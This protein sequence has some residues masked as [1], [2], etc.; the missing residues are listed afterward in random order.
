MSCVTKVVCVLAVLGAATAASAQY[1]D[2]PL[3]TA[4][5]MFTNWDNGYR[6]TTPGDP[7]T[8][9]EGHG[10]ELHQPDGDHRR[11]VVDQERH[12]RS[13]VARRGREHAA[14]LETDSHV[15]LD[16]D[17]DAAAPAAGAP[18]TY[19]NGSAWGDVTVDGK[20]GDGYPGYWYGLSGP[21]NTRGL[22]DPQSN[23]I[24]NPIDTLTGQRLGSVSEY[25]LPNTVGLDF[26]QFQ[27]ELY[28]WTGTATTFPAAVAAG[29]QVADSGPFLANAGAD[30]YSPGTVAIAAT[31]QIT[32]LNFVLST[33]C[34]PWS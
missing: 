8:W 6:E 19:T 32:P 13:S 3:G 28:A 27:F 22:P 2:P 29:E 14:G 15:P 25:W 10:T 4:Y 1:T 17:H 11:R 30:P 5:F 31:G 24:Y 34:P 16:D 7:N 23:Y 21:G 18:P 26:S 12:S 9:T 33:T 20:T